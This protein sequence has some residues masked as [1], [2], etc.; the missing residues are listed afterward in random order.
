MDIFLLFWKTC[1]WLPN[2]KIDFDL[3]FIFQLLNLGFQRNSKVICV[4]FKSAFNVQGT[5][6]WLLLH[7]SPIKNERDIVVRTFFF[8]YTF[9]IAIKTIQ[10]LWW[11]R[12]A[13]LSS[14]FILYT[15]WVALYILLSV[16]VCVCE[17]SVSPD[18][19]STFTNIYRHI[20]PMVTLYHI[21]PSSISLYW[22]STTKYQPVSLIIHHLKRHSWII[23]FLGPRGPLVEPSMFRPVHPSTRPQ[24]F[25]LSS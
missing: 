9:P 22:P 16:C 23:S 14:N 25:F 6:L 13:W 7:I 20:S 2:S 4:H 1:T 15:S 17:A 19:I 11:E 24:Q 21:I 18:Q 3:T 10:M 8:F 5:P 12:I